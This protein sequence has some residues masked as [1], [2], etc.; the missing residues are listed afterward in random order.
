[1]ITDNIKNISF[2]DG[3]ESRIS[4]A[5][6][7]IKENDFTKMNDGRVEIEGD[8]IYAT[9]SRYQSKPVEQGKWESHRKYADVQF[10]AKGKEKIGYSNIASMDIIREYA[11]EKDIQ[12][13]SG[14]GDFI[15]AGEGTFVILFPQDVHMPG[16]LVSEETQ[17]LKVVVK[18]KLD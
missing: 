12:F 3:L 4:A 7:F 15:T 16:I 6:N 9:V 14:E 5:L 2:Y 11:E 18:V 10:V 17:V 8:N 13:L 1:M